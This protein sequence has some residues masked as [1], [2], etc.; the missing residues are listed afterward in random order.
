MDARSDFTLTRTASGD[1]HGTQENGMV[2]RVTK[3]TAQSVG[4]FLTDHP[5]ALIAIAFA[6]GLCLGW[7]VKRR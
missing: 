5:T 3:S 7:L 1:G 6:G 2:A 4:R